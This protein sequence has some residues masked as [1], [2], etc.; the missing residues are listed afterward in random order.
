MACENNEGACDEC[1]LPLCPDQIEDAERK[2]A[3]LKRVALIRLQKA[4]EAMHE[5]FCN[6]DVGEERERAGQVY[7]NIRV[8]SRVAL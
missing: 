4:E 5:Y 3:D 8:A 2:H 7:E 6:C 1:T